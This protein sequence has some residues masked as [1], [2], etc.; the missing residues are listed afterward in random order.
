MTSEHMQVFNISSWYVD[1]K[2]DIESAEA[3]RVAGPRY[4]SWQHGYGVSTATATAIATPYLVE[5]L[6]PFL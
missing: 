3:L 5:N 6:L 1:D 4:S 2:I